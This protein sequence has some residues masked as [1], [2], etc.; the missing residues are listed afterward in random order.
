MAIAESNAHGV[1][2]Y[3]EDVEALAAAMGVRAERKPWGL[4]EFAVSDPSGTLVRVG[5]PS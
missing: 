2:F 4:I 1:Y 3:A 5:W